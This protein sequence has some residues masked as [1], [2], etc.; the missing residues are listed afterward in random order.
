MKELTKIALT[1]ITFIVVMV[2]GTHQANQ[3]QNAYEIRAVKQIK[4]N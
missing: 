3:Q 1:I 2:I 4:Q